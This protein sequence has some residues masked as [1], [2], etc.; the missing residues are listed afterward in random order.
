MIHHRNDRT[1]RSSHTQSFVLCDTDELK[2]K[3]ILGKRV[4]ILVSKQ[5]GHTHWNG[6]LKAGNYV[7]IPFS[8]GFWNN[9]KPN[10]DFTA[11]IHSSVQ[12]ELTIKKKPATFLTDCLIS[13]TMKNCKSKQV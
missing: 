1:T 8:S 11:V 7:L 10:R 4:S 3:G 2:S 6:S 13:A 9:T 5:G 12:L